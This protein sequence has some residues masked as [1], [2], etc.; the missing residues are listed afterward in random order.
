M[1]YAFAFKLKHNL[2]YVYVYK[3]IMFENLSNHH[4]LFHIAKSCDIMGSH[5]ICYLSRVGLI[6]HSN[7]KTPGQ[8]IWIITWA[9]RC[10]SRNDN[11]I[12]PG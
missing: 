7:I 11:K 12:I 6:N 4:I 10:H 3:S 2:Y 1:V 8:D 9:D 5:P